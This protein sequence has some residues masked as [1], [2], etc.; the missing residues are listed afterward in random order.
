MEEITIEELELLAKV[1]CR[2]RMGT[3]NF[4]KLLEQVILGRLRD[5]K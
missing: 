1:F 2:A 3:R 5:L 4:H